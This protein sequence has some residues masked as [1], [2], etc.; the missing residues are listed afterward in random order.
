MSPQLYLYLTCSQASHSGPDSSGWPF[1]HTCS[2]IKLILLCK[3]LL[4]HLSHHI[5]PHQYHILSPKLFRTKSASKWFGSAPASW[6]TVTITWVLYHSDLFISTYSSPV[7]VSCALPVFSVIAAVP[8]LPIA[9][10]RLHTLVSS[11][12]ILITLGLFLTPGHY[13]HYFLILPSFLP[14]YLAKT[15]PPP[16]IKGPFLQKAFPDCFNKD[17]S[18]YI[19]IY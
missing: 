17:K 15:Y 2:D 11:K 7:C 16:I 10:S 9:P 13:S 3:L 12:A 4:R 8:Y 1:Q 19:I 18:N 14:H 6:Q 5:T